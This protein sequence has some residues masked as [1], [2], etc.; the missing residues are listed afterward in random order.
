MLKN[1]L[2]YTKRFYSFER[3]EHDIQ[4]KITYKNACLNVKTAGKLQ[5][6]AIKMC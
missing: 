6:N 3:K 2:P 1:C 5:H 4:F